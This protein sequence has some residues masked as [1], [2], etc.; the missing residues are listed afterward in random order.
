MKD[1]RNSVTQLEGTAMIFEKIKKNLL[2]TPFLFHEIENK[3]P[4]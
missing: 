4:L 3:K 2:R 1:S